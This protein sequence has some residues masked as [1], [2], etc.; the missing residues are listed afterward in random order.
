M[1]LRAV[2]KTSMLRSPEPQKEIGSIVKPH[3][4]FKI[5]G[6]L[7]TQSGYSRSTPQKA[8]MCFRPSNYKSIIKYEISIIAQNNE[9]RRRRQLL[10]QLPSLRHFASH[11]NEIYIWIILSIVYD[12][13]IFATAITRPMLMT[14]IIAAF[15]NQL[16]SATPPAIAA[17]TYTMITA[18]LSFVS[19]VPLLVFFKVFERRWLARLL[20]RLV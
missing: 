8:N 10:C 5:S 11:V 13:R 15:S 12:I 14:G 3:S 6:P 4:L 17:K 1:W 2:L 7:I 16:T 9:S 20:T 19:T 18:A